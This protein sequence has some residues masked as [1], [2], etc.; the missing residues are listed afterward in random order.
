MGKLIINNEQ[1]RIAVAS[2]LIK[3]KYTVRLGSQKRPNG[4]SNEYYVEY[5]K[6][7]SMEDRTDES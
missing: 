7:L 6:S 1:D 4:R 5:S 2:I 3:N